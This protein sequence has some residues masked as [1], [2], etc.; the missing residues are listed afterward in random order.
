MFLVGNVRIFS[1]VGLNTNL[2]S[3]I[4]IS[5]KIL[6]TRQDAASVYLSTHKEQNPKSDKNGTG[7]HSD[8]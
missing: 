4:I 8:G 1:F 6:R 7:V 3:R 2:R 5:Q